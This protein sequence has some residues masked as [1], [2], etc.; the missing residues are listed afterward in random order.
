MTKIN[1]VVK[2]LLYLT[3]FITVVLTAEAISFLIQP[4]CS[5]GDS[6]LLTT[7]ISVSYNSVQFFLT[8]IFFCLAI[9]T[10]FKKQKKLVLISLIGA[11]ISIVGIVLLYF[12]ATQCVTDRYTE[13]RLPVV[14]G[15][16]GR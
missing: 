15:S 16:Q 3:T 8:I 11:A 7:A 14:P 10:Y 2:L 5:Q 1:T 12:L 4:N 13:N 6:W 9:G